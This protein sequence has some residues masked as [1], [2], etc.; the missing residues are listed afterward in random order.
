MPSTLTESAKR[1]ANN[2]TAT[3]AP[4]SG[5]RLSRFGHRTLV[6]ALEHLK[7]P[8]QHRSARNREVQISPG[9]LPG[10]LAPEPIEHDGEL[11]RQPEMPLL[12]D[13]NEFCARPGG[14]SAFNTAKWHAAV[15]IAKPGPEPR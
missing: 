15:M 7:V 14:N 11:A 13:A 4:S 5:S 12:L 6:G 8:T 2:P 9:A 10:G 1:S 3:R